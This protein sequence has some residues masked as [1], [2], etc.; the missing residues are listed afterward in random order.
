MF[1]EERQE[2]ILKLLK[3]NKRVS[4]TEL[5]KEFGVSGTTIRIDL[6]ELEEKGLLSRTHGGAILKDDPVFGEDSISSRY[7]KNKE[8]K[9]QIV[10]KARKEIQDGDTILI[11]SGTTMLGLAELLKDAKNLTIITNDLQVA[12]K[13]QKNVEIDLIL[14]GG[15]VRT[16]FECT[17]GG[18]GMRALEELS[19]DKAFMGANAL[20]IAKGA[21]TPNSDNAEMK[22]AMM[23]IARKRYLLCDSSKIG[24]RT[25]C[26][27]AKISEFDVI[28]T[29]DK[30]S[31]DMKKD[32]EEQGTLVL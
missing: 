31:L 2:K 25:V 11:D 17:V 3:R 23:K 14:L 12:L 21:T 26:S 10:Q 24:I 7:E 4:N 8:E 20:S 13:L 9:E 16:S 15:R 5:V 27:F 19:V 32:M 18:M 6:S 28:I 1:A 30:V 22:R 29:D